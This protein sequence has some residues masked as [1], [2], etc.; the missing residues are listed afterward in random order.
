MVDPAAARLH[1]LPMLQKFLITLVLVLIV[2]F[3]FK[4]W[5]RVI[6][7]GAKAREVPR[8][9]RPAPRDEPAAEAEVFDT[10][11]CRVCGAYVTADAGR[12]Q[13]PDCPYR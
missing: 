2:W 13:R 3:G 8:G 9:R 1:N 11:K 4:Y 5:T 7:T 6:A 12:C 10:E